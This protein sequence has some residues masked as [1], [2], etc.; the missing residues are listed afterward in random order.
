MDAHHIEMNRDFRRTN[1]HHEDTKRTKKLR[2]KQI[3]V[4]YSPWSGAQVGQFTV[5]DS[6][7]FFVFFV[8]LVVN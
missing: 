8:S 6:S 1:I 2:T 3:M 4:P 5:I 7:V